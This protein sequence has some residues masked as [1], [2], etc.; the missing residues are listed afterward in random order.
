M[1]FALDPVRG[2][3]LPCR[4]NNHNLNQ[5]NGPNQLCNLCIK[6]PFKII[7]SLSLR[8]Q[9]LIFNSDSLENSKFSLHLQMH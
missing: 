5:T 9:V 7:F 8:V 1:C 2:S 3:D 4:V 6:K